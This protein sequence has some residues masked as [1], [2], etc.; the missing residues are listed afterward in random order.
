MNFGKNYASVTDNNLYRRKVNPNL[1]GMN[2]QIKNNVISGN[3]ILQ[4]RTQYENAM[5]H[6]NVIS[7][8]NLKTEIINKPNKVILYKSFGTQ[9][10]TYTFLLNETLKDVVSVKLLRGIV[11][12]AKA[13]IPNIEF[14][15]LHIDELQKNYGE[16]NA[17]DKISNSFAIL[18]YEKVSDNGTENLFY[19]NSFACNNDIKYFDPPLNGLSK[20]TCSLFNDNS[21]TIHGAAVQLKLELLIET[22]EKLRVY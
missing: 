5:L 18:D 6:N 21:T 2:T 15:V 13:I 19:E 16:K 7:K 3:T 20:L 17:T 10:N 11:I 8:S 4:N 9:N 14:F 1:V 12:G 22:K